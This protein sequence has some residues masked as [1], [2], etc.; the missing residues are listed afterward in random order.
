MNERFGLNLADEHRLTLEQVRS[1]LDRDPSLDAS[2]RVNTRETV[3]LMFDPKVEDRIQEIV[4]TNFD[5]YKRITDDA[6]SPSSQVQDARV[7]TCPWTIFSPLS[8]KG[9]ASC[10]CPIRSSRSVT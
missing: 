3:R 9:G 1:G 2:A 4:E 6:D 8:P 7:R 5:L 10:R